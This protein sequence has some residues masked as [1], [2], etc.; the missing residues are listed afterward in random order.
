MREA[1]LSLA[2]SNSIIL[3]A[4]EI[5]ENYAFTTKKSIPKQLAGR[6]GA[7]E[8]GRAGS[9]KPI[10][11]NLSVRLGKYVACPASLSISQAGAS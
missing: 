4:L 10:S 9:D 2:S 8:G 6:E 1:S 11:C 5:A 7:G 3:S